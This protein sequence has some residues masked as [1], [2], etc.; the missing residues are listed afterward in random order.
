MSAHQQSF[1]LTRLAVGISLFGHG[2][3]RLPKLEK[4]SHGMAAEFQHSILPEGLVLGFGYFLPFAEFGIGLLTLLGLLTRPAAVAGSLLMIVLIFGT[5]AIEKY[6]NI[7]SMLLHILFFIG[8]L[9]FAD[10]Y[11]NWSLDRA[12]GLRKTGGLLH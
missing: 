11:D 1:L 12:F 6:E 7:P 3:V 4:F 9:V 5:T 2:L 8:V 10:R